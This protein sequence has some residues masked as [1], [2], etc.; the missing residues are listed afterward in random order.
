MEQTRK[1]K[2]IKVFQL[3]KEGNTIE[4]LRPSKLESANQSDSEDSNYSYSFEQSSEDEKPKVLK[5]ED[6]KARRERLEEERRNKYTSLLNR[7]KI[8]KDKKDVMIF[9]Y[10]HLLKQKIITKFYLTQMFLYQKVKWSFRNMQKVKVSQVSYSM[11]TFLL[12]LRIRT[13]FIPMVRRQLGNDIFERERNRMKH[14][15]TFFPMMRVN[16][17]KHKSVRIIK[18]YL[19]V[20]LEK[21]RI[22]EKFAKYVNTILRIDFLLYKQLQET[23]VKFSY[24]KQEC[25]YELDLLKKH[26]R[27]NATMKDCFKEH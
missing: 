6:A 27:K 16:F 13:R 21:Y 14:K 9:R 22:Y 20:Y 25:D 4:A 1:N 10:E 24:L 17:F 5:L 19:L 26:Y 12:V 18:R 15:L 23:R 2:S 8:Y 7:Q 3:N 11:S